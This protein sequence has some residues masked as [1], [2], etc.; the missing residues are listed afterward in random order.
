MLEP[1]Q[2][3]GPELGEEV[4]QGC[5][6]FRPRGIQAPLTVRVH[7]DQAGVPEYLQV[8]RDGLL[9]DVELLGDLVH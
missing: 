9:G 2:V 8:Q 1:L 6:P 7:G 3:L 5:E 4:P